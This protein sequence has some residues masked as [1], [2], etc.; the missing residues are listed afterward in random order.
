MQRWHG[1]SSPNEH[2]ISYWELVRHN[3]AQVEQKK[4]EGQIS[5]EIQDYQYENIPQV[6]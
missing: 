4:G 5:F 6:R 2:S 1:R 3:M